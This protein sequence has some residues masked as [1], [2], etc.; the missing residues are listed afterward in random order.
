MTKVERRIKFFKKKYKNKYSFSGDPIGEGAYGVVYKA[1]DIDRSIDVAIKFFLSSNTPIGSNRSWEIQSKI[2]N[3][4]IAPIFTIENLRYIFRTYKVVISRLMPGKSLKDFFEFCNQQKNE[5]N[6][7]ISE[8]I[9][10]SYL[11]SLLNILELCHSNGYGHGDLHEG[12]VLIYPVNFS[13]QFAFNAILIDF[14]NASFKKKL[15]YKSEKEKI[16]SDVRLFKRLANN[17]L[18]NWPYKKHLIELLNSYHTISD[19]RRSYNLMI[20]LIELI[21]NNQLSKKNIHDILDKTYLNNFFSFNFNNSFNRNSII[22][23][24]T[25]IAKEKNVQNEFNDFVKSYNAQSRNFDFESDNYGIIKKGNLRNNL[26]R[27]FFD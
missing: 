7:L 3:P 2:I 14:D 9:A 8:D 25:E 15:K 12:N 21:N 20:N 27:N 11:D 1:K 19:I 18:L 16:E 4:Q 26:Y 24:M 17:L 13:S 22:K 23:I 5:N 10:T 6:I